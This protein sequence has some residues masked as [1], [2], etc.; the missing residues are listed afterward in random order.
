MLSIHSS[1]KFSNISTS[2]NI[3]NMLHPL[4][5]HN[6]DLES[7]PVLHLHLILIL[8]LITI[9]PHSPHSLRNHLLRHQ[10]FN[11]MSWAPP[12]SRQCLPRCCNAAAGTRRLLRATCAGQ[13]KQPATASGHRARCALT[14]APAASTGPT[15]VPTTRPPT[16]L[17]RRCSG[18]STHWR[19]GCGTSR[20]WCKPWQHCL[21][22]QLQTSCGCCAQPRSLFRSCRGFKA[23]CMREYGPQTTALRAACRRRP[24]RTWSLSLPRVTGQCTPAW[25]PSTI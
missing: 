11:A 15:I 5:H 14:A 9:L 21:R 24:C 25:S 3:S 2:V 23:A 17:P 4:K 13:R 20:R 10:T 16:Q 6:L 18:S 19:L 7:N 1:R 8:N 12:R 22:K